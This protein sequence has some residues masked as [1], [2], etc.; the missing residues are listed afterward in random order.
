MSSDK[1]KSVSAVEL[2]ARSGW[3]NRVPLREVYSWASMNEAEFVGLRAPTKTE[4]WFRYAPLWDAK[5]GRG[6]GFNPRV[7][8]LTFSDPAL[9]VAFKLAFG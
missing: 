4:R 7:I 9:T 3:W 1:F 2:H 8:R 5:A 6:G